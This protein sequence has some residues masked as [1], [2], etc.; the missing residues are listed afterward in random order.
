MAAWD[1]IE[2]LPH[3]PAQGCSMTS[4]RVAAAPTVSGDSWRNAVGFAIVFVVVNLHTLRNWN[5]PIYLG[6]YGLVALWVGWLYLRAP[7]AP[8]L[9]DRGA[10]FWIWVGVAL[11]GTASSLATISASGAAYGTLR[12]LFALP[13]WCALVVFTDSL[14]DLRRHLVTVVTFFLVAS[15]T[16]PLQFVIGPVSWFPAASI[17]GDE[18]RY[19][20]LVG[21]LTSI[22]VVVGC[23]LLLTLLVR[24]HWKWAL[25]GLIAVPAALSLSKAAIANIAIASLIILWFHRRHRAAVLGTLVGLPLVGGVVYMAVPA[26]ARRVET[27][28][29]SFGVQTEVGSQNYDVSLGQSVLDRLTELPGNTWAAMQNFGNPLVYLTGGGYGMGDTALVTESDAITIMAHNQLIES[30]AVFGLF[31][32]TVQWAILLLAALLLYLAWRS[33]QH[34]LFAVVGASFVLLLGNGLQANGML[35]QPSGA[36]LVYLSLFVALSTKV[37]E[38][39]PA[40]DASLLKPRKGFAVELKSFVDVILRRWVTVLLTGL[41]AFGAAFGLGSMGANQNT[42]AVPVK[43]YSRVVFLPH[44]A[45]SVALSA[46]ADFIK[47]QMGYWTQLA[48]TQEVVAQALKS[49]GTTWDKDRTDKAKKLEIVADSVLELSATDI[50]RQ[51]AESFVNA[52][53]KATTDAIKAKGLQSNAANLV[54]IEPIFPATS[55]TPTPTA[56]AGRSLTLPLAVIVGLVTAV[57][58]GLVHEAFSRRRIKRSAA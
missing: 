9:A 54:T 25:I 18:V 34:P 46:S 39:L 49:S 45:D 8:R 56:K 43:A 3:P 35:Y 48:Q 26:L 20:S 13:V 14:N 5:Q 4:A 55:D 16:L 15:W 19:A 50:D 31:G 22:G 40:P 10:F 28:L 36:S 11:L 17:R 1:I 29:G 12:F 52:W 53:V 30:M 44:G 37:R 58:G 33:T 7:K 47:G 42:T 51:G 32:G 2:C 27:V 21:S 41:V 24:S 6:I 57:I 23:Y 38:S